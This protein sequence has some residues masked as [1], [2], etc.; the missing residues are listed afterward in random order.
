V[1]VCDSRHSVFVTF[2]PPFS[3]FP[4]ATPGNSLY[5]LL[6]VERISKYS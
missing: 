2:F 5:R 1:E 4:R 6:M 3:Q